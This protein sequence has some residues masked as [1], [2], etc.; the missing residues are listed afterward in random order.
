MTV[1]DIAKKYNEINAK[2]DGGRNYTWEMAY[3]ELNRLESKAYAVWRNARSSENI[4]IAYA[5]LEYVK[6]EKSR[7]HKIITGY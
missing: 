4:V 5:M 7:V 3:D 2:Y 1:K 6:N